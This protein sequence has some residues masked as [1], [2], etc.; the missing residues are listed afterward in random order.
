MMFV[1]H[2]WKIFHRIT[3]HVFKELLLHKGSVRVDEYT[4]YSELCTILMADPVVM[5]E[6]WSITKECAVTRLNVAKHFAGELNSNKLSLFLLIFQEDGRA[7]E[8]RWQNRKCCTSSLIWCTDLHF[9]NL[10]ILQKHRW[11][12]CQ[13]SLMK[14]LPSK[15]VQFYGTDWF[16]WT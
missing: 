13:A 14:H 6:A 9:P 4:A 7:L 16:N 8:R 2:Y 1:L 5:H 11:S 15:Y 12:D 10:R 3:T